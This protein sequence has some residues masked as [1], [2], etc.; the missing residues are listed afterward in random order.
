M[1]GLLTD[2]RRGG[3]PIT[4][5]VEKQM[6]ELAC[7][8]LEPDVAVWLRSNHVPDPAQVIYPACDLVVEVLSESSVKRDRGT[9]YV[10]YAEAGIADYWIVDADLK[11]VERYRERDGVYVAEGVFGTGDTLTSLA[12][13]ALSFDAGALFEFALQDSEGRRLQ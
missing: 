5:T 1:R 6:I 11:R 4:V 13:P 12:L 2:Y 3:G 9:K 7:S 10:E 8:N